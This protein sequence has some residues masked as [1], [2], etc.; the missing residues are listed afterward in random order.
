MESEL[1]ERG[2]R[3]KL[4]VEKEITGGSE[5][6]GSPKSSDAVASSAFMPCSVSLV[7][8]CFSSSLAPTVKRRVS[9]MASQSK[10]S[11]ISK[12]LGLDYADLDEV[13]N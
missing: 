6:D 8:A 7:S 3:P 12:W 9:S 5:V 2:E 1:N 4:E 13:I 10:N 11:K